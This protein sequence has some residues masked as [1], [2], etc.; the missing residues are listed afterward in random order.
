VPTLSMFAFGATGHG[1][2]V[3]FSPDRTGIAW[4]TLNADRPVP[5]LKH[6]LMPTWFRLGSANPEAARGHA[7]RPE[8][9]HPAA[10]AI[11]N[12]WPGFC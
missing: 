4:E 1:A 2:T 3:D 11:S 5:I 8:P 7:D 6:D 9:R 10:K 12:A